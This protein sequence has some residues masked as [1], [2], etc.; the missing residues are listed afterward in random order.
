MAVLVNHANSAWLP[1][2]FLGV[3]SFFVLSGYVVAHSSISHQGEGNSGF[4]TRRL[5]RLQPALVCMLL[6]TCLLSWPAGLLTNSHLLT[7]LYSLVG[8]SN[9][10]LVSQSLDYF[11]VSAAENPFTH[12]WSL[13]VEEQF[14]LLFPFLISRPRWLL[15]LIPAALGLWISM[16][17]QDPEVAF[18]LMP[19]RFWELGLGILLWRW[20][21]RWH[22]KPWV[23]GLG[24]ATLL[25]AFMPV[26]WQ[27]WSTPLAVAAAAP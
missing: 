22:P 24:L 19:A 14:Y 10:N 17:L 3:D 12:T 5:R 18:Y 11:G 8:L 7:G 9:L 21:N 27:L 20:S 16:Q 13:G 6:V 4:Y 15:A 25:S 26:G 2:G 1:G 23:G